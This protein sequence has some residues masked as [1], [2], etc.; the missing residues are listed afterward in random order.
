MLVFFRTRL[1]KNLTWQ[2]LSATRWSDFNKLKF[3]FESCE[4]LTLYELWESNQT[5]SYLRM[6]F[7]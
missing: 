6:K 7:L 3:T 5:H 4:V 2:K 1:G